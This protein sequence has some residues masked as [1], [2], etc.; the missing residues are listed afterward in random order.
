MRHMKFASRSA[1]CWITGVKK[2]FFLIDTVKRLYLARIEHR[3]GLES[4]YYPLINPN[5]KADER[6]P[7]SILGATGGFYF[8]QLRS[9]SCSI[10]ASA[11]VQS[12]GLPDPKGFVLENLCPTITDPAAR[13]KNFSKALFQKITEQGLNTNWEKALEEELN[14]KQ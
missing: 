12:D 10:L 4:W 14:K 5:L 13:V 7:G 1:Q 9:R 3:N 11:I 8:W 6:T 2:D